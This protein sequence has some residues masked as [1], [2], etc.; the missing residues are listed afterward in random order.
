MPSTQAVST[1]GRWDGSGRVSQVPNTWLAM[2]LRAIVI[3]VPLCL[4]TGGG[5]T[6][7]TPKLA[8]VKGFP[9]AST[10]RNGG[11][12]PARGTLSPRSV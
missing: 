8:V 2:P 5:P 10:S 9:E 12:W 11:R 4:T 7:T 3:A 1:A 6:L